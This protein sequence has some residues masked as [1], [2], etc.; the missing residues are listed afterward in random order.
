MSSS[1]VKTGLSNVTAGG[2]DY[3]WMPRVIKSKYGCVLLHGAAVPDQYTGVAWPH[4]NILAAKLAALGI[5]CIAGAMGGDT[6]ANDAMMTSIDAARTYL[7][8]QV[9]AVGAP[10]SSLFSAT[11]LHIRGLSMGGGAG[12]RFAA[13]NVGKI[14]SLQGVIPMASV[15]DIY[16]RN[17]TG[18]FSA[19]IA[20]AWAR[21]APASMANFVTTS[22]ST[23]VTGTF[24]VGQEGYQVTAPGVAQGTTIHYV[25]ATHGT[26]SA[27]ASASAT[28]TAVL[29]QPLPTSGSPNADIIGLAPAIATAHIANRWFYDNTSDPYIL[30]ATVV[31]LA[32][33]A[34]GTAI[35]VNG[36][37]H[38]DATEGLANAYNG[39]ADGSDEAA[40]MFAA[41]VA[42][43]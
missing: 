11:K 16:Q 39:G 19:G 8:A 10:G 6:Y 36:S 24:I 2:Y 12:A 7:A 1:S 41:E 29:L 38:T 18:A 42:G 30:P 17:P 15:I 34:G 9:A 35:Q 22:G 26:L 37:G 31:A 4:S 25:D 3:V 14:A 20:T 23:A 27:N 40:F 13:L 28:V 33:A 32:T 21:T 43:A 5:P